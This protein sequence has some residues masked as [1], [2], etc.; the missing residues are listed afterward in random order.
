MLI[1]GDGRERS[2][3]GAGTEDGGRGVG[4]GPTATVVQ[5]SAWVDVTD[6]P[7]IPGRS[8]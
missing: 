2:N 6:V 8:I 3:L 4:M 1:A 5:F 7:S